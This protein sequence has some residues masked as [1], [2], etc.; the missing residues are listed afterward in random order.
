MKHLFM[1]ELMVVAMTPTKTKRVG[2]VFGNT[3]DKVCSEKELLKACKDWLSYQ[4][5][6]FA[7]L[8]GGGKILSTPRG[9]MLAK[10]AQ[11]GLPD[12]IIVH[13]GTFYGIELKVP[14]GFLTD[15]QQKVLDLITENGGI[16]AVITSVD[17]LAKLIYSE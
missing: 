8:E 16:G 2:K 12:L 13:N 3:K 1:T 11:L 9:K 15:K 4:K 14:G 17:E 5:L 6:W 10:S 7:R